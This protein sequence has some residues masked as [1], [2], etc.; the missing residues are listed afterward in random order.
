[1][2]VEFQDA[3]NEYQQD[4]YSLTDVDD[5]QRAGQEITAPITALGIPNYDQAARILKFNLDRAIRGNTYVQF[6]TSVKAL[7]IQPGDLIT[8]TYLKEGFTQQPFRVIK[9]APDLNYRTALI[10][11]QIHDDA[12]YDDTNGQV[13]GNSGARRQPGSEVGLPRPL[14]GTVVDA[15]GNVQ[16][17]VTEATLQAA[18]GST[19]VEVTVAFSAPSTVA[20]SA[21]GVPLLSLAAEIATSGGTLNGGATLYYAVSA[22][23]A[24]GGEGS[25]SFI[26]PAPIPA[27]PSTNAITLSGLS[28][29]QTAATFR[30]YRGSSPA[31]LYRIATNQSIASQ[32]TD[33][34]LANQISPAPDANFDHANFYW[35]L[36]QQPEYTASIHDSSTIGNDTLEMPANSYQGMIVRITRG[37]GAGQERAIA[38]NTTTVLQINLP[39]DTQPDATSYFVVA[40]SGWH[41]GATAH[42][43]P[44]Q[45][46][47]PNRT[48][49]TVHISGRAANVNNEESP[50]ELCTLTRWV[51]GG[52]G[53]LD[54]DVPPLPSFGLGFSTPFGGSIDLSGVSF[55]DLTN[56]HTISAGTFTLYYFEELNDLPTLALAADI[57]PQ[58]TFADLN[59]PSMA[60]AGNF[61]QLEAEVLQIA[62][63]LNSGSRLQLVRGLH[64]S[65]IAAHASGILVYI[66]SIKTQIVPFARDFFGS[67]AS[68][69]WSFPV[70]L[71]DCRITSAELFLTNIKGNSPTAA[72][73]VTQATDYGLRTLAGGQYSFQVEGFL[74]IETGATPDIIVENKYSVR[75]VYAVIRQAPVGGSIQLQINQNGSLYCALT[76]ADGQTISTPPVDGATL[77]VLMAGARLSLD[78]NMVGTTNPGADLTVVIRL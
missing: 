60:E 71:P 13:P 44:V 31:L 75:D 63:V 50:L 15:N 56:T 5:V 39:W 70:F 48:G 66:L 64:T 74:A 6:Q 28:F 62:A 17:G 69:A 55:T 2:A 76:I 29:P 3:L 9:I 32:F 47:I 61:I 65:P 43:S 42:A 11:A 46:E 23:D 77:P 35:R 10:T 19:A 38:S 37:T 40:E 68:G 12:W 41:P 7:G 58:D 21:P 20:S 72:I 33:S 25:L 51:I 30:V 24:S 54:A 34:G 57:G 67:P 1:L 78:I 4:S 14:M 16:F 53:G 73:C 45:F 22:V 52:A 59:E 18:D 8:L 26:V 49:A 27:G 36:E